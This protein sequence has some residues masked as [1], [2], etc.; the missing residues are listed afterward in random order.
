M[1]GVDRSAAGDHRA[2][3][4]G[5]GRSGARGGPGS[6]GVPGERRSRAAGAQSH[7]AHSPTMHHG[8]AGHCAGRAVRHPAAPPAGHSA[9]VSV[10][11]AVGRRIHRCCRR[12]GGRARPPD[13]LPRSAR[14][15]GQV[16]ARQTARALRT[17]R[18]YESSWKRSDSPAPPLGL[19]AAHDV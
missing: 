6:A 5:R 8:A 9:G 15:R 18:L 7:A 2:G 11:A 3:A 14:R 19:N 12:G 1:C 17:E 10:A 16:P 13:L 4:P